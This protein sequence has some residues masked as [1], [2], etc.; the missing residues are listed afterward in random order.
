MKTIN[1]YKMFIGAFVPNWLMERTEISPGAKLAY[2]RLCQYAGKNGR[3]FPCQDTF[4]TALGI[5]DRQLRRYLAELEEH[6]LVSVLCRGLN[7][8]N[9]YS[10]LDHQWISDDQSVDSVS[11]P[12]WTDMSTQDRTDMSDIRESPEKNTVA[13]ATVTTKD[14]RTRATR[15]PDNW[16]PSL[17][18]IGWTQ[19]EAPGLNLTA[20]LDAFTDYWKAQP[21]QKGV[22][23]DWDATWRNWIRREHEQRTSR[24]ASAKPAR[25]A[26][27]TAEERA[28]ALAEAAVNHARK[29][30]TV[31][32]F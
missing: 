23:A 19:Q 7:R 13:N 20:V 32:S 4:A 27:G 30:A 6:S 21:G 3:A 2:G 26:A 12:A 5:S 10:F 11:D 18:L 15:I 29:R 8:P 31:R 24:M 1:P 14:T 9:E 25:S 22:K 16:M 28:A 17:D